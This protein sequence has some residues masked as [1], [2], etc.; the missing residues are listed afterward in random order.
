MIKVTIWNEGRHDKTK[1]LVQE[2]YP[3]GIHGTLAEY[4]G[5]FEHLQVRTATLD[6]PEQG[7]S[8]SL[9]NDTDVMLWWGHAYHSEVDDELV[10]KIQAR[11][12]KGMGL[13]C[14]HSAHH[15]KIFKRMLGTTCDLLWRDS[16]RE[17]IWTV[18]PGHPIAQGIPQ[19]FEL[20]EEEMYGEFFDIPQPDEL[21]FVGWFKGGEIFRSG[22]TFNRGYGKIF[23]FQP[24]HETNAAY[25]NPHVLQILKNAVEWA[26]PRNLR[27]VDGCIHAKP[28]ENS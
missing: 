6:D 20:E 17:R 13:I 23:Y 10:Q 15:S 7:L 19:Y 27:M 25:H 11:V 21:V 16:D 3:K 18:M 8:D 14:L 26:Q 1:K 4:L 5:S 2:M 24:G 9:L 12:L 28:I 22:C